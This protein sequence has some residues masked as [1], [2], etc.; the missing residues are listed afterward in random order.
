MFLKEN[1]IFDKIAAER[2]NEINT[3]NNKF[4]HDKLAYHFKSDNRTPINFN[5]FNC[6]SCPIRKTKDGFIDIEKAKK[7]QKN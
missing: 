6:P 3:L 5:V 1:E 7:N 4:K 2:S